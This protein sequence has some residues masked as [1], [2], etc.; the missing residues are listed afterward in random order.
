MALLNVA[1]DESEIEDIEI[2]KDEVVVPTNGLSAIKKD[3]VV[4]PSNG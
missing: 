1:C 2:K 3:E 4:V